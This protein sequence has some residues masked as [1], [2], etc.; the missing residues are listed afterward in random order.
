MNSEAQAIA[1]LDSI[2]FIGG[3]GLMP[4]ST[5]PNPVS[6]AVSS[7]IWRVKLTPICPTTSTTYAPG[8][9]PPGQPALRQSSGSVP[10]D[11]CY[12]CG[13][14]TRLLLTANYTKCVFC[15]AGSYSAVTGAVQCLQCPPGFY[16]T[17]AGGGSLQSCLAWFVFCFVF[18]CIV[19][20][21]VVILILLLLVF[22]GVAVALVIGIRVQVWILLVI[23]H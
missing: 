20:Q 4:G 9:G 12:K 11:T 16:S 22:T 23:R 13:P 19:S 15:P 1:L 18:L 3:N 2:I 10:G 5:T 17:Q 21:S 8:F 7:P 14:G 6:S